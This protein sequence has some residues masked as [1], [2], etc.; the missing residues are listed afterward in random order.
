[1]GYQDVDFTKRLSKYGTHLS[2]STGVGN[3][4]LNV[5]EWVAKKNRRANEILAKVA[6]VD[7]KTYSMPWGE[8]NEANMKKS[9]QSIG[10]GQLVANPQAKMIGIPLREVPLQ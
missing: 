3:A 6:N 1:M 4:I 7:K 10:K 2:I 9:K 8:M 5:M